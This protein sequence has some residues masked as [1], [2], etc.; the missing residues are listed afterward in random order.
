MQRLI[1]DQADKVRRVFR[2]L[3]FGFG[4]GLITRLVALFRSLV[5]LLVTFLL[6]IFLLIAFRFFLLLRLP[7]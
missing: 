5:L 4:F 2:Q 3:S 7:P 1:A 6:A